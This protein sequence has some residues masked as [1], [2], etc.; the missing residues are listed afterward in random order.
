MHLVVFVQEFSYEFV[1]HCV[2]D[3]KN[4]QSQRIKLHFADSHSIL[5]IIYHEY[6]DWGTARECVNDRE[7]E[8][9]LGC[10]HGQAVDHH[11]DIPLYETPKVNLIFVVKIHAVV[12]DDTKIEDDRCQAPHH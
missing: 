8:I 2:K 6:V 5:E 7:R 10:S 12:F 9:E 3:T 11:Y 4:A 1:V